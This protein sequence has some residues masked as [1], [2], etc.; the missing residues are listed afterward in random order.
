[1][2]N[3]FE[4]FLKGVEFML[5][6]DNLQSQE[7]IVLTVLLDKL[8]NKRLVNVANKLNTKKSTLA[9]EIIENALP[10][11]EE[12]VGINADAQYI[13]NLL[14]EIKNEKGDENE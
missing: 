14:D 5:E 4:R 9:R 3:N 6:T 8:S 1:M 13:K 10:D 12:I 7:N 11:L 2:G